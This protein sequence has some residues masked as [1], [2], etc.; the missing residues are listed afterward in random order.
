MLP[1]VPAIL[2]VTLLISYLLAIISAPDVAMSRTLA[3][4]M[5][6]QHKIAVERVLRQDLTAGTLSGLQP[7]P[8]T[9]M[10]DWDSRLVASA[11][12]TIVATVAGPSSTAPVLEIARGLNAIDDAKFANMPPSASG[13]YQSAGGANKVGEMSLD[14][15]SL[16]FVN[17][18]PVIVTLVRENGAG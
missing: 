13:R 18:T 14:G 11:G 6:L 2:G 1:L 7:S 10:G 15:G 16:P 9:D 8:F 3:D 17:G 12:M 5:L 4:N